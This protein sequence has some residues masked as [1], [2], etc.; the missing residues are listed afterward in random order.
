M[1]K[2]ESSSEEEIEWIPVKDPSEAASVLHG[3]I[4]EFAGVMYKLYLSDEANHPNKYKG[5]LLPSAKVF[6]VTSLMKCWDNN[7]QRLAEHYVNHVLNWKDHIDERNADFFLENNHI[8]VGP[9][10]RVPKPED[11]EFFKD[12]W[13]P[14]ST[15]ALKPEEKEQVFVYFDTMLHYAAEWKK[16][17]KYVA[18]WEKK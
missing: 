8:Y 1:E 9:D 12:L 13:R 17:T 5:K 15:F 11:I 6:V 2:D 3:T 10:G 18:I 16:M 4:F 7:K 14:N